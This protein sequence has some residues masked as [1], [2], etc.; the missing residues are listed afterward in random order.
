MIGIPQRRESLRGITDFRVHGVSETSGVVI[1]IVRLKAR[2]GKNVVGR[3]KIVE[4]LKFLNARLK[5][6]EEIF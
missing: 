4:K 5:A 2:P 3:M 6:C 1:T